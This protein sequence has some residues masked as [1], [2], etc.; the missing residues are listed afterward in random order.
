MPPVAI[1][2]VRR[3]GPTRA[4]CFEPRTL[5]QGFDRRGEVGIH[6]L[7][8]GRRQ[9]ALHL[10]GE[11]GIV[12]RQR[13]ESALPGFRTELEQFVE[14]LFLPAPAVS[15]HVWFRE[16][17]GFRVSQSCIQARPRVSVRSTVRS[18]IS[19]F[20]EI[21]ATVSPSK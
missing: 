8:R 15:G 11:R 20:A 13:V 12:L 4:P 7:R 18:E 3:Y 5:E 6:L 10:H 19:R 2:P 1:S 9:E 21:S 14:Q 16:S 17:S